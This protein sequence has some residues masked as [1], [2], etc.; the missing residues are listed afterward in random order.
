MAVWEPLSLLSGTLTYKEIHPAVSC[1]LSQLVLT[2]IGTLLSQKLRTLPQIHSLYSLTHSLHGLTSGHLS[3]G[4]P[5]KILFVILACPNCTA[6]LPIFTS[7]NLSPLNCPWWSSGQSSWLQIQRSQVR[8]PALPGFLRS[9]GFG[10]GSTKPR[11]DNWGVT[12]KESS[13]SGL[14]NKN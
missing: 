4:F 10:T 1:G 11:E 3:W 14:D 9:S 8:F 5:T 2:R 6:G 13:S 12:W 7:L